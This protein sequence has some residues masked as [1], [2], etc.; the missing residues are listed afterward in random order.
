[1]DGRIFYHLP[2]EKLE[3]ASRFSHQDQ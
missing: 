2:Q 1:M 3:S